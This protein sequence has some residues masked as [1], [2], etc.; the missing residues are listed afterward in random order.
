MAL[1]TDNGE[2]RM[3]NA[4]TPYTLGQL[5]LLSAILEQASPTVVSVIREEL[6]RHLLDLLHAVGV[7]S[8][9]EASGE[10]QKAAANDLSHADL[11]GIFQ[12]I[13]VADDPLDPALC[14]PLA[15]SELNATAHRQWSRR[16]KIGRLNRPHPLLGI[17]SDMLSPQELADVRQMAEELARYH[18]SRIDRNRPNKGDQD[19]LLDGLADIFIDFTKRDCHRYCLPHAQKSHF[20]QFAHKAMRP[21]YGLT[22]AS[23][24]SISQRWKRLKDR[25]ISGR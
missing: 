17:T 5:Q 24:K 21:C 6:Q 3:L 9:S 4:A 16:I 8:D 13:A 1:V 23:P 19:A 14:P 2:I 18:D 11:R 15:R 22:E 20:I 25:H 7:F 12:I 10:F